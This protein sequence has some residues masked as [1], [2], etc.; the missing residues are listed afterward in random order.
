MSRVGVA[1]TAM[2]ESSAAVERPLSNSTEFYWRAFGGQ[3]RVS[4][5]GNGGGRDTVGS[6]SE[7][8]G[9]QR[10]S[11]MQKIAKC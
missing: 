11:T 2:A 10:Q 1:A 3:N 4:S 5:R 7:G 6:C 8:M 9:D